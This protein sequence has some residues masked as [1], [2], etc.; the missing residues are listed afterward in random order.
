LKIAFIDED[1]DQLQTYCLM[2]EQ[3]FPKNNQEIEIVGFLPSPKLSDMGYLVKDEEIVAIILDEQLKDTGIATYLGIDLAIY[4]R[5]LDKKIPIYI[6]TSYPD[7]EEILNSEFTIEDI[8]SKQDFPNKKDVVGAR[9]MRRIDTFLDLA[10]AREKEFENLLRKSI[11]GTISKDETIKY[12][13][14]GY[15]RSASF[16]VDEI[17]SQEKLKVL[18]SLEAQINI[19]QEKLIQKI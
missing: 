10:S 8:L 16:E 5:S 2:L 1:K 13:E 14:L 17:F 4:L 12:T 18:D 6:L 3:C 11:E 19:L 7:S 9:I 15:L